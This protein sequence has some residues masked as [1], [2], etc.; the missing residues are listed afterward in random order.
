MVRRGTAV[1]EADEADSL[2]G[3]VVGVCTL[4]RITGKHAEVLGESGK[5]VVVGAT[6]LQ[7]VDGHAAENALTITSLR[8]INKCAV[9]RLIVELGGPVV[10]HVLLD[11][12]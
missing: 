9:L 2:T 5:V 1:V 12:A 3:E 7:V 4:E 6:S 11:R 8:D 10:G